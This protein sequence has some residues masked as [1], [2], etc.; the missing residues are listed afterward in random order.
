MHPFPNEFFAM[1]SPA[2]ILSLM[3]A[4]QQPSF[5][6][7]QLR[8]VRVRTAYDE[9]EAIVKQYFQHK[10]LVYDG[11]SLFIRALKEEQAVEVWVKA[12]NKSTFTL[13]TTYEFCSSSGVLGPKRKEGD[14]QIPEG[15]YYINHFNP[16][17]N[18]H[19]SLGVSYPNA[20]DRILSDKKAPGGAIYVHGNCVTL[21]CIPITDERIK[22]LYV[23]AV[24]A[25]NNG[26]TKIPIHIYPTRM[27]EEGMSRLKTAYASNPGLISFWENLRGIYADFETGKSLK[28]VKVNARGEYYFP[29][30]A[31]Q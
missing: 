2:L 21:G 31:F 29:T 11:F 13:L 17:S 28:A 1:I 15:I 12:T 10:G 20:S 3:I 18:F 7:T 14:L 27:N 19:L 5:K 9:K 25:R 30:T 26:Q 4:L 23:L 16:L 8:N 22:E 24:E 6:E